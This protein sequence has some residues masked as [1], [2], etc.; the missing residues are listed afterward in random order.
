MFTIRDAARALVAGPLDSLTTPLGF[1]PPLSLGARDRAALDPGGT[2]ARAAAATGPGPLRALTVECRPE[3]PPLRV[4]AVAIAQGLARRAPH[5]RWLV[6]ARHRGTRELLIAAPPPDGAGPVPA[7]LV[8]VAQVRESDAETLAALVAARGDD[9]VLAHLRWREA[10]GRDALTRRFY[11]EL[12]E[13]VT[14]LAT[15]AVGGAPAEERRTLAIL[16]TSRLLF[17]AFLEAKGW[18]DGDRAF[19]RRGLE[20]TAGAGGVHRRLLDPLCF[21]TLNTPWAARAPAARALGR[22]PFLNG[23][24]F[25]RSGI[26]KRCR[27]VRFT[28]DALA[29]IIGGLLVRYRLTARET[30]AELSDAAVDPEMLGR[31]FERLM[32]VDLRR[33]QGT[34]YTPHE[35]TTRIVTSALEELDRRQAPRTEVR[36][37]DPACGSGA[38]LVAVLD[39]LAT[40]RRTDDDATPNAVARR[41]VLARSIY[42]VD[43]DP[44]AVW[45]CQLRLWLSVVVEEEPDDPMRLTPLPN[46]DRNIREGDSLAGTAFEGLRVDHDA[47]LESVRLRY[48]RAS[49][50]RKRNLA[51]VLDRAERARAVAEATALHDRA[52][53]ERRELV[54]AAR[55][56]DLFRARRGLAAGERHELSRLRDATRRARA[57]L[58]R[59]RDGGALPFAFATHFPEIAARGGFDLVLGNP[60]WVRP[61]AVAGETRDAL[62]VRFESARRAAWEEGAALA[63]AGHGFASQADLAALFTERAVQLLRPGGIVALLLPAKLWSTLAGGGIRAF[64]RRRTTLLAFED[65][66]AGDGG[67]DA[68]VYPTAVLAIADA[69]AGATTGTPIRLARHLAARVEEHTLEPD[70]LALDDS[71][72]APWLLHAP[73]VRRAFDALVGAG[74]ALA[75]T[76]FGRPLLG[77]K[78]GCNEAFIV[79][80][81]DADVERTLLRPLVRGEDLA[82]WHRHE[83]ATRAR[84]LWTH[85]RRGAPLATLPARARRHLQRWRRPLEL[86]TDGRGAR[87]WA[88]FR[89][90]SART[91]RPRVVWADI[92]R[93]PRA[94]VLPSGD[95][96]VPLNTCYVVRAPSEDDAHALAALLNSGVMTAWLAALAE[97]ARGGYRRYLGW[98]CARLPVPLDWAR[99]R[100]ALAPIGREA[101]EGRPPDAAV[102]DAAVTAAYGLSA[103]DLAPLIRWH[104]G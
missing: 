12:E 4:S 15:T 52:V 42:G 68:A 22:V 73:E 70:R 13:C 8:D 33:S 69:G 58:R 53:A 30:T 60:P 39:L 32:A 100:D 17:L 7:L 65:W 104:S 38:F 88:L 62:R 11:R 19:L 26:E 66:S 64:L 18:L 55:S 90:D 92:G 5:L 74:T 57:V 85:D 28:D 36:V 23:G 40:R 34:F 96:T 21:G 59:L 91:D 14:T 9:A 10:L 3:S 82:P 84:I 44:V 98:T 83:R 50:T 102:L 48:V 79:A 49:G 77:V 97:P 51:R 31:A 94:L 95:E 81:G 93:T 54:L 99:A 67:F 16:T 24:L 47:T 43:R 78:T 37:L 20:R 6:V 103:D 27:A 71:P 1:A 45:L 29:A 25:A 87:W 72:G 80:D 61:H 63:A 46:L 101:A 86:R 75:L 76:P 56:P 89:T 2:I 41:E 35:L